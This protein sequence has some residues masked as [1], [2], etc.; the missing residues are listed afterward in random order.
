MVLSHRE[1]KYIAL[2]IFL[3]NVNCC[4]PYDFSLSGAA[5][6]TTMAI[7]F[8]KKH[9]VQ[10]RLI[11]PSTAEHLKLKKDEWK[12]SAQWWKISVSSTQTWRRSSTLQRAIA[13]LCNRRG[14]HLENGISHT[15][16]VSQSPGWEYQVKQPLPFSHFYECNKT[17]AIESFFCSVVSHLLLTNC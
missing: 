3:N 5:V 7:Y 16:S 12:N 6:N 1:R 11:N 13:R 4:L 15:L 9:E 17:L 14:S 10:W 8:L 2:W